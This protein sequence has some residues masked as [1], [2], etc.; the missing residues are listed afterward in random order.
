MMRPRMHNPRYPGEV[1][2]DTVC[3]SDH[4]VTVTA[5]AERLAVWRVAL[6]RGVRGHAAKKWRPRIEPLE[7]EPA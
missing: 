2:R 5:F 3:A 7:V 6:S 1:L 4:V